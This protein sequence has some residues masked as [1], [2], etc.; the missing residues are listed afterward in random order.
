ME[1]IRINKYLAQSGV[2]SRRKVEQYITAGFVKVNGKVCTDLST[3]VDPD[4][5]NVE[6]DDKNLEKQELKYFLYNKPGG[7][8]CSMTKNPTAK[9]AQTIGDLIDD[10]PQLDGCTYVGRLDKDSEGLLI[11]SN[12]GRI[13]QKLTHPSFAKEK[14]YLVTVDHPILEQQ[15]QHMSSGVDVK[16]YKTKACQVEQLAS[17]KFTIVISEGK[18]RQIRHM[19]RAVGLRVH[20]LKR[21]RIDKFKL[22]KLDVGEFEAVDAAQFSEF[23]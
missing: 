20:K 8:E 15:L 10:N 4:Q 14:E 3:K 5:D 2:G 6:F 11:L 18:N 17:R 21:I 22:T 12:D 7:I 13:V 16:G 1:L 23:L 9:Y 19:C